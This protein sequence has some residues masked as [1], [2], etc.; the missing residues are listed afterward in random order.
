MIDAWDKRI[1]R[2][3]RGFGNFHQIIFVSSEASK[4]CTQKTVYVNERVQVSTYR[5]KVGKIGELPCRE[6]DMRKKLGKRMGISF[7]LR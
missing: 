1:H 5:A 3:H 2:I 7:S 6:K 4:K